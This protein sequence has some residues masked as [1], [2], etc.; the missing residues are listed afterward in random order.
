MNNQGMMFLALGAVGLIAFTMWRGG[1]RARASA[2]QPAEQRELVRDA[3]GEL[4]PRTSQAGQ[5]SMDEDQAII[6]WNRTMG[7]S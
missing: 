4:I 1:G 5:E 6:E 7:R 3:P 2:P